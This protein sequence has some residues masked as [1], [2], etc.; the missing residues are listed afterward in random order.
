MVFVINLTKKA[1]DN[2]LKCLAVS[3]HYLKML[4]LNLSLE[5]ELNF[6]LLI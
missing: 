2:E 5:T 6:D 4:M 1:L 3:E